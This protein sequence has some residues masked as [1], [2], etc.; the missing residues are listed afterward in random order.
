MQPKF[1]KLI[2]AVGKR[3]GPQFVKQRIW[4]REHASGHWDW[5]Q[6]PTRP[7]RQRDIAYEVLD[8]L[9]A[10]LDIMDLGCGDGYTC[11]AIA[12]HYREYLGVD[13]SRIA[14]ERATQH[15]AQD[16]ERGPKSRFETGDILAFVA[17][18]K[19]SIIL[20]SD[21]LQYFVTFQVKRILERYSQFLAPDGVLIARLC[22]RNKYGEIVT[23]I[24]TNYQVIEEVTRGDSAGVVLVLRPREHPATL[25]DGTGGH[26]TRAF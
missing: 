4:D 6:D 25:V 3:I 1:S 5:T 14:V 11:G 16:P 15:I 7:L 10:G 21:C 20:F 12:A 9:S 26:E 23:H 8:R 13:I 19:F 18:K 24:E 22:D 2:D 17:P